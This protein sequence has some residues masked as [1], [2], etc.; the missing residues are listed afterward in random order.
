MAKRIY[1]TA[2]GIYKKYGRGMRPVKRRAPPRRNAM[3]RKAP[4]M[5]REAKRSRITRV[6]DTSGYNQFTAYKFRS[7]K[8]KPRRTM[9]SKLLSSVIV[10]NKLRFQGINQL[11]QGQGF[12]PISHQ[13]INAQFDHLPVYVANL[14]SLRNNPTNGRVLWRLYKDKTT[15]QIGW[16]T[17][18]GQL[19]DGVSISPEWQAEDVEGSVEVPPGRKAYLDWVRVKLNLWG[20][21]QAPTRVQIQLVK[22]SNEELCPETD[23][24]LNP[25]GAVTT[26]AIQDF[27]AVQFWTQQVKPLINNPCSSVVKR[28]KMRARVLKKWL[29]EINPTSTTESD[30]DPHCKFLDIFHRVGRIFNYH[31]E[32]VSNRD[33]DTLEDAATY[34]NV[35]GGYRAYPTRIESSIYLVIKSMQQ[36]Y[37]GDGVPVDAAV[38]STFDMNIQTCWR[39]IQPTTV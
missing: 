30:T 23:T 19:R 22:M 38:T 32:P 3:K 2:R 4:Q 6:K 1:K 29:I 12:F 35:A 31:N 14:T 21:K 7:G 24:I 26:N 18:N 39:N 28:T 34:S 17:W 25:T 13:F 10:R 11:F 37:L 33:V 15:D 8:K 27:D 5:K 16:T 20:K 9:Q 36:D